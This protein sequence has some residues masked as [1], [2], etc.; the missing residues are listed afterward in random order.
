MST[1]SLTSWISCF[2]FYWKLL[3]GN[4]SVKSLRFLGTL[5]VHNKSIFPP[6]YSSS[7]KSF[8][9]FSLISLYLAINTGICIIYLVVGLPL[10]C[11]YNSDFNIALKSEEY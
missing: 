1:G 4:L 6:L 11:T 5:I 8:T 10:G 2:T 3:L 7:S 9:L